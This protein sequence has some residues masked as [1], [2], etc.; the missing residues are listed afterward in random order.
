[1]GRL[2]QQSWTAEDGSARSTVEVLA[3][4]LGAEPP[5]GDGD[6]EQSGQAGLRGT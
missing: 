2:Q 6:T 3:E 4:Q 5:L 1:M